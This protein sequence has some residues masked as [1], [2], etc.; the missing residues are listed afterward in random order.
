MFTRRMITRLGLGL[1]IG[2]TWLVVL[3]RIQP[4]PFSDY[5]V[6][7]AVARRLSASDTLYEGVWDNKDPFVYYSIALMQEIGHPALWAL[8]AL[9]FIVA[10]VAIFVIGRHYGLSHIWSL[11]IGAVL[12]PIAMIP[13]HYFPGTTHL[14]GVSLSL[15]AIALFIVH[16]PGISGLLLGVLIFFKL[17]MLPIAVVGVLVI[18]LWRRSPRSMIPTGATGLAAVA[19][20]VILLAIRGEFSPYLASLVHNVT[21]SQTNTE[22]GQIG[23]SAVIAERLA[24]LTEVHVFISVAVIALVLVVVVIRAGVNEPWLL[25]TFTFLVAVASIA[26]IGKFPHHAQV[27]GISGALTLV[28][29]ALAFGHLRDTRPFLMLVLLAAIT[30]GLTGGPSFKG[31]RDALRNPQGTWLAMT[32]VD[33][34]TQDI[35]SSGPARSFAVV[36]GAGMPRSEGLEAWTLACRHLAQR[37]WESEELLRESLAC[38]PSAEI[39]LVPQDFVIA[40]QPEEYRQFT[41]AVDDLLQRE[42]ACTTAVVH[43]VCVRRDAGDS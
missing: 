7:L 34:A 19:I 39:L 42:Y 10:S 23:L 12:V 4:W 38:F 16:R 22:S 40:Q 27:L 36:Q 14:P 15:A 41:R 28:T 29:L 17:S 3:L 30:L 43:E 8:E 37:P 1:A 25:T 20:G 6:F 33:A 11:L 18:A 32:T 24:V 31:Y 35:L 5:E 9:W 13:F 2:A 21:Y 26:I